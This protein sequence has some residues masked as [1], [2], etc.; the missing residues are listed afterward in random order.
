MIAALLAFVVMAPAAAPQ[1]DPDLVCTA[2]AAIR[3]RA[4]VWPLD[5]C[6]D[7]ADSFNR[8]QA[9]VLT[10]AIGIVESDL[11]PDVVAWPKPGKIADVGLLGVRCVVEHG[12]CTNWPVRG[13]T[14]DELGDQAVNISAGERVLQKKKRLL[15]K[16]FLQGYNG[17][18]HDHGYTASI[19]A[20]MLALGG[21]EV[22][23]PSPR[24]R[25]LV[26]QIA[27]AVRKLR[28]S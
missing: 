11:R 25:K 27:A 12:R 1:V 13:L 3:H 7:A 22:K 8:T 6:V 26:S 9:P 23:S 5:Q 17:E 24:I 20:I 28:R 21:V 18:T 19:S 2:Q 16:R 15:G 14:I 10:L 4:E